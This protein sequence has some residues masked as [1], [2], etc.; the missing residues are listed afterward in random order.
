MSSS[1]WNFRTV[2]TVALLAVA[3]ACSDG[4]DSILAPEPE[5]ALQVGAINS[6]STD[7]MAGQSTLVGSVNAT[8]VGDY[9]QITYS[10]AGGWELMETHLWV[11]TQWSQMPQT[12]TGNPRIGNFPY[13]SGILSGATTYTVSVDLTTFGLSSTMTQCQPLTLF[14]A[15]HS[16]VRKDAGSGTYQSE[17]AWGKGQ[18][19]VQRGSWA[20]GFAVTIS[21]YDDHPL[22]YRYETAFGFGSDVGVCFSDLDLGDEEIR[23]G[24][25]WGWSNGPL[26]VG[27]YIFQLYAGAGQCDL[28]KGVNVGTLSID[29]DGQTA[30]VTYLMVTGFVLDETHLYMGEE[31]LPRDKMGDYTVA[32]GQYPAQHDLT[33]ATTDSYTITGLSGSVY[34]V[35]H[36]VV[37]LPN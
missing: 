25:R 5:L 3:T 24:A 30:Q 37:G 15:A 11:G 17:T 23:N 6:F 4:K 12:R 32:P 29:Y 16:A 9:L 18:P 22:E 14:V 13:G 21:C 19:L 34:L 10:T 2:L 20:E 31:P 1:R 8:V 35:A 27:S 7:L 36:A 26:S 28:S 33:M